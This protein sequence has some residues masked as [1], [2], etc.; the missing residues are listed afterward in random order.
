[1]L[2][3]KIRAN[4]YGYNYSF[5]D[6][7]LGISF[8]QGTDVR[9]NYKINKRELDVDNKIYKVSFLDGGDVENYYAVTY[10]DYKHKED[11]AK[12]NID[13]EM[14]NT[15]N[16]DVLSLTYEYRDK[17]FTDE[18]LK[19]YAELEFDKDSSTL[20]QAELYRKRYFKR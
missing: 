13:G 9:D 2:K 4:T 7:Q 19:N 1:M 10:E 12:R 17:R 20:S 5:D 6:N 3:K 8:S 14:R 16:S 18:E 15:G 11:G